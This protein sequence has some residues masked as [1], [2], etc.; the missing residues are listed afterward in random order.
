MLERCFQF[1][2]SNSSAKMMKAGASA[3]RQDLKSLFVL[4]EI[5]SGV[6]PGLLAV[7]WVQSKYLGIRFRPIPYKTRKL[8]V[9]QVI[10]INV[11][12][13]DVYCCDFS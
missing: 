3:E 1:T 2:R 7:C 8:A 6:D 12:R 10:K 11:L 5:F 13:T 9:I 4:I